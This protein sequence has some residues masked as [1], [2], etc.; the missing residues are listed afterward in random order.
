[1]LLPPRLQ[2]LRTL[3]TLD[4]SSYVKVQAHLGL[5]GHQDC[6]AP[7]LPLLC[8]R[9]YAL[10]CTAPEGTLWLLK[11]PIKGG[12]PSLEALYVHARDVFLVRRTVAV[13]AAC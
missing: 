13:Q 3:E 1:M 7:P 10:T 4:L 2:V 6:H 11:D 12:F 9:C 5:L 8:P